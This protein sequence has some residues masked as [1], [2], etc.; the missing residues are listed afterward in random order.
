MAHISRTETRCRQR[1][2]EAMTRTESVMQ[3]IRTRIA[4]RALGPGERLPSIRHFAAVMGVSPSTVVEAYGRLEA[5]GVFRAQ[6]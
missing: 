4:T 3:A 6:R 2:G 1:P 5:E